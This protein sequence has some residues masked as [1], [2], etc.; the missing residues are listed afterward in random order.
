MHRYQNVFLPPRSSRNPVFN[1]GQYNARAPF[2]SNYL[3]V[4]V[5]YL[6]CLE[7]LRGVGE[8]DMLNRI[9]GRLNAK[10]I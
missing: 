7:F 2:E 10:P 3:H 5:V 6:Q 8:F 1:M 9:S 4:A